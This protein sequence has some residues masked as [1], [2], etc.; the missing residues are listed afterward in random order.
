[1]EF[2][3]FESFLSI[4]AILHVDCQTFSAVYLTN[5]APPAAK[6]PSIVIET[7]GLPAWLSQLPRLVFFEGDN[8]QCLGWLVM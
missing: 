6:S 7:G 8:R 5:P 4:A 2:S 1:M 3:A